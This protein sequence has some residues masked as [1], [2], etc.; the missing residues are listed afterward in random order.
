MADDLSQEQ[1]VALDH[2]VNLTEVMSKRQEQ[3]EALGRERRQAAHALRDL[4]V[5]VTVMAKSA[6]IVPQSVYKLLSAPV[7]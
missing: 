7:E 3:I 6:R 1:Q 4:G 5:P 2:F